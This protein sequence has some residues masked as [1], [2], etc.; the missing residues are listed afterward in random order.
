MKVGH[1]YTEERKVY[2]F[3]LIG[4]YWGGGSF[5]HHPKYLGG[6][7]ERK[8]IPI[9]RVESNFQPRHSVNVLY[10]LIHKQLFYTNRS[11]P[12]TFTRLFTAAGNS[13]SRF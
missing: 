2:I 8:S 1:A 6:Y 9:Q 5:P 3:Y 7:L 13:F 11:L 10:G 4:L 12:T